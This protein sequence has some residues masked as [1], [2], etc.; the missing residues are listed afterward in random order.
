[1]W[2]N[3]PVIFQLDMPRMLSDQVKISKKTKEIVLFVQ[4]EHGT[5]TLTW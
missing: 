3:G 1:M 4:G 2:A 5:V